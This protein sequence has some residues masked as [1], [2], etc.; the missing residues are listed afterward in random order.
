MKDQNN[1]LACKEK[2]NYFEK[3]HIFRGWKHGCKKLSA[4][5]NFYHRNFSIQGVGSLA[6]DGYR[7]QKRRRLKG[8]ESFE[9]G[10]L[11]YNS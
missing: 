5:L 7:L 3:W 6:I 11:S 10:T 2:Q 4:Y 1:I 8:D 9:Y